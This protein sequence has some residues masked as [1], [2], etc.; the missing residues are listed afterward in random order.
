MSSVGAGQSRVLL[1]GHE[2]PLQ[3][4]R[5]LLLA[6]AGYDCLLVT[7]LAEFKREVLRTPVGLIILCQTASHEEC[8]VAINFAAEHARYAPLLIMFDYKRR[9]ESQREYVLLDSM[10]GP[11]AFLKTTMRMLQKPP[12]QATYAS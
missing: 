5:K 1:F 12:I 3:L 6:R 11:E 2:E 8:S 9:C 7:N 10:A 4:S